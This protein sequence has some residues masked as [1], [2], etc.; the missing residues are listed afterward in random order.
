MPVEA[1]HPHLESVFPPETYYAA[2]LN[3]IRLG[4]EICHARKPACQTCPLLNL[5]PFGQKQAN[6]STA[7]H[8]R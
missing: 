6:E 8:L 7:L 4:R 2:H 1:A 3:F 5:C